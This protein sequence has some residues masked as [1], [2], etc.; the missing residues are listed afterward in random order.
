MLLLFIYKYFDNKQL[1]IDPATLKI[2]IDSAIEYYTEFN[3]KI[4]NIDNN[5]I[6]YLIEYL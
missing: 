3:N 2:T 4:I 6:K 1:I 5:S